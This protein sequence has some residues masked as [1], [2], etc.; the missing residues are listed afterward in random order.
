[1]DMKIYLIDRNP[2]MIYAWNA[3]FDKEKDIFII[4]GDICDFVPENIVD[5]VVSPANSF[6]LMDGG[7][8]AALTDIFGDELQKNV[9][10]Y[11]ME[12]YYGEQ[13][14]GSSFIIDTPIDGIKLIH[15]PTM[16]VPER[17]LDPAVVYRCTRT[18]LI[19]AL[20]NN[21]KSILLP[22]FGGLAG[23]IAPEIL[24]KMMWLAIHQLKAPKKEMTWKYAFDSH[25]RNM[26]WF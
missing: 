16:R 8:D 18:S 9:Q 20:Q 15:T 2:D 7:F 12:N 24:A 5:C 23:G 3:V 1:M 11:I 4:H 17:I 25:Y 14:V 6:G 26:K 10:K 19:C 13:P 22:A 21:V